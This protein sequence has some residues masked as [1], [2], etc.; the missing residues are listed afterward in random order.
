MYFCTVEH[1]PAFPSLSLALFYL[2]SLSVS[3]CFF[4]HPFFFGT[5]S[6]SITIPG[7]LEVLLIRMCRA[8]NSSNNTMFFD[9]KFASPQLF[10]ALG[11]CLE[12][13]RI[14]CYHL[15]HTISAGYS[16]DYAYTT[17]GWPA[18][19]EKMWNKQHIHTGFC[20]LQFNA[21]NLNFHFLFD[22]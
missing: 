19:Y 16:E 15:K 13:F 1:I 10:K 11:E 22:G 20:I 17:Y 9:G 18:I 12:M 8:Y 5:L 6:L 14:A 4:P 3:F 7:C 2:F 21:L